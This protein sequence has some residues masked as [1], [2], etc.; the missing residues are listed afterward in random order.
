MIHLQYYGLLLIPTKAPNIG[1]KIMILVEG[2]Q[3]GWNRGKKTK[4]K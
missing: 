1:A 4:G 2:I 3:W